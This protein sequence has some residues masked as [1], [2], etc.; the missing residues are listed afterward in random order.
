MAWRLSRLSKRCMYNI[1]GTTKGIKLKLLGDIEEDVK[2][3]QKHGMD[4]GYEKRI[5]ALSQEQLRVLSW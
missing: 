5:S 1:S 3:N 2:L 4:L